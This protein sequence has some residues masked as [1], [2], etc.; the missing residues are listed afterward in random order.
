MGVQWSEQGRERQ[1]RETV[2]DPEKLP[3][4]RLVGNAYYRRWARGGRG[5]MEDGYYGDESLR[6]Y[7]AVGRDEAEEKYGYLVRWDWDLFVGHNQHFWQSEVELY[8]E[9]RDSPDDLD[10]AIVVEELDPNAPDVPAKCP[11]WRWSIRDVTAYRGLA[12]EASARRWLSEKGILG[13]PASGERTYDGRAVVMAAAAMTGPTGRP[14][15]AQVTDWTT[16][17]IAAVLDRLDNLPATELVRELEQ[18]ARKVSAGGATRREVDDLALGM[19]LLR[20]RY[21]Q[22]PSG[23]HVQRWT[24]LRRDVGPA[25]TWSP[26]TNYGS[27][28]SMRAVLDE[29]DKPG[30]GFCSTT[31]GVLRAAF[32][33][34]GE[35]TEVWLDVHNLATLPAQWPEVGRHPNPD[36]VPVLVY[37]VRNDPAQLLNAIRKGGDVEHEVEHLL[38]RLING[39]LLPGEIDPYSSQVR[40]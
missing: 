2:A 10:A 25:V 35:P 5:R 32:P 9:W 14:R 4:Q 27:R 40:D 21:E 30:F 15:K 34:S 26:K 8:G 13:Y 38:D 36:A 11:S 18:L 20:H 23:G 6:V 33:A 29:V 16:E 37:E 39:T 28:E 17:A 19:R 24:W 12:S 7:I 31:V 1:S 3:V 22:H